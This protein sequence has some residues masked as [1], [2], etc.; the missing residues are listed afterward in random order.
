[1]ALLKE[2]LAVYKWDGSLNNDKEFKAYIIDEVFE[3]LL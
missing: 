1:M 2:I 3:E